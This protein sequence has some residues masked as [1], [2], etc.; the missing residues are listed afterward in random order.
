MTR[1][2]TE[3]LTCLVRI[4]I[5]ARLALGFGL[6]LLF[7]SGLLA[8]GLWR[9]AQLHGSTDYMMNDKVVSLNAVTEMREQ[10]R[11]MVTVL[12]RLAAPTELAAVP[13]DQTA[14]QAILASYGRAEALAQR[15]IASGDGRA[16]LRR[17]MAE[18][19]AVMRVVELVRKLA[20]AGDGYEAG[21]IL[22]AELTAP[23]EQWL[24][25]LTE[26][27]RRQSA[28]MEQGY[29]E[30]NVHYRDAMG[31][32][33]AIGLLTLGMGAYAAWLI[34]RTIAAPVRRAALAADRIAAGDLSHA[35]VAGTG[36]SMDTG[37][38]TGAA[39]GDEVAA[40]LGALHSMQ[41]NLRDTV[42]RIQQGSHAIHG[43]AREIASGNADLSRRTEAQAGSLQQTAASIEKLTAIARASATHTRQANALAES[44]SS[45]AHQGGAVVRDVVATMDAIRAGSDKI[46]DITAVIDSIAFQTNIL[47]L[48]A[49]VE[50]A[51]AGDQGRGF[52]VVAT[53]VRNLAQRCAGAARQIKALID[54]AVRQAEQGD[55][56][57]RQAGSA[58]DDIVERV[59]QV[60][61][62]MGE[63]AGAGQQQSEGMAQINRAIADIDDMTRQNARL[64]EQ[65]SAAADSMDG[66]AGALVRLVDMFT[67][68]SESGVGPAPA[69]RRAPSLDI[70]TGKEVAIF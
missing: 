45:A 28:E 42:H 18:K 48:N 35:I 37:A 57:A 36:A 9:M 24:A 25:T 69:V 12:A 50:A 11:A 4:K 27:A 61:R 49:A 53:E 14:L 7:A 21:N 33:V 47:A 1:L 10:G 46:V 40:M 51:R 56:L 63:I 44:A 30:L 26:L 3:L 2:L 13:R 39:A 22:R 32:M 59:R 34:T 19:Q 38:D 20:L 66:Q 5:G 58:M 15:Q 54:D 17:A 60:A 29:A 55:S 31:G 68:G 62:L 6:V 52:A 43:A 64:V 23:H 16:L 67:L 8:M 70:S 41:A 65:S